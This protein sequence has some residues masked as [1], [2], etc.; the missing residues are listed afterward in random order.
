MSFLDV[1][2]SYDWNEMKSFIYSRTDKDVEKVLGLGR[3]K[4]I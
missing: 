2:N 1:L 3:L 4:R